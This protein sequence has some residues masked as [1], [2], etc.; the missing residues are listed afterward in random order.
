MADLIKLIPNTSIPYLV[1]RGA[2]TLREVEV[3][4]GG[5]VSIGLHCG[6]VDYPIYFICRQQA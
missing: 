1:H 5:R 6:I 4:V 2:Y 3:V